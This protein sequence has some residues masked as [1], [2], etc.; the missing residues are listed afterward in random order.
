MK[1]AGSCFPGDFRHFLRSN[2]H[3]LVFLHFIHGRQRAEQSSLA[4]A[5]TTMLCLQINRLVRLALLRF[6]M[7]LLA[8]LHGCDVCAIRGCVK[9][10]PR[11]ITIYR[12]ILFNLSLDRLE[13]LPAR[14]IVDSY[15]TIAVPEVALGDAAELFLTGRV[16][17]LHAHV[18]IVYLKSLLFEVDAH[19]RQG[20]SVED[21]VGES[22]Q[23]TGLADR[24]VTYEHHLVHAD[25]VARLDAGAHD[26]CSGAHSLNPLLPSGHK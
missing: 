21:V 6:L 9:S 7:G 23:Q 13:G 26:L 10:G 14:G 5:K 11:F 16:P 22:E 20:S 12:N 3:L 19:S 25:D 17:K 2:S 18:L 15:A 4:S 8:R 24:C 1:H